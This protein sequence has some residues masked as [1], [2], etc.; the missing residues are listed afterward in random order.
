M[1]RSIKSIAIIT[2]LAMIIT[3]IPT[4]SFATTAPAKTTGVTVSQGTTS[5]KT[6][7]KWKKASSTAVKGYQIQRKVSGG[8][9]KTLKTVTSRSTVKYTTGTQTIGKTYYYRVRAYKVSGSKKIYGAWSDAKKLKITSNKFTLKN[10]AMVSDSEVSEGHY[11]YVKMTP[12]T[13]CADAD[14]IDVGTLIGV[15]ISDDEG[16]LAQNLKLSYNTGTSKPS[17]WKAAQENLVPVKA[18][19]TTWIRIFAS[20]KNGVYY[21]VNNDG[22]TETITYEEFFNKFK[23]K[24]NAL[25]TTAGLYKKDGSFIITAIGGEYD[26]EML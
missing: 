12:G 24:T 25:F 2:I 10:F 5:T 21:S 19:K 18:G 11:I 22:D 14:I 13:N 9:Y 15:D 8:S 23:L 3:C 16:Y 7:I 20:K 6:I 1:K 26:V 17:T 4:M